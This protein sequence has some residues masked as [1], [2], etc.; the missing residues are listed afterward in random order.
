MFLRSL[1]LVLV[2]GLGLPA[3]GQAAE[4]KILVLGDSLSAAYGIPVQQ[5]WVTLLQQRISSKGYPHKVINA[6]ISGD[7]TAGGLSRLPHALRTYRPAL[8]LIELGGNDG[9]RGLPLDKSR[10]NLIQMTRLAQAVGAAPVL[11][12][13]R[14]PTSYGKDYSEKFFKVFDTVAKR[15]GAALVP[16]FLGGFAQNPKAFQEDGIHPTAS[17]QPKKSII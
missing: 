3:L 13:M 12:E 4:P 6:S 14:I 1:F 17:S 8:V 10:D 5:G 15:E 9:L 16:F 11:F 7:T 2:W